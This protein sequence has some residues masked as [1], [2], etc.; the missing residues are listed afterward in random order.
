LN[1]EWLIAKRILSRPARHASVFEP[2]GGETQSRNSTR[3]IIRITLTGIIISM[4]VMI[5]AIAVVTGFQKEIRE[6]IS[7]FGAHIQITGFDMNNSYESSP[8]S[9]NQ[10]FYPSLD[11]MEGIRHIQVFATKAGIIKTG[12]EIQGVLLKGVGSDYDWDF[13]KD[14]IKG[15]KVLSLSDTAKSDEVLL[16][17]K[18]ADK[19]KLN[20]GD[21][22][23]MHF[24]QMPPRYRK[25]T[26]AGIYS[27]GLEEFDNLFVFCDIAHIRKLNDWSDTQ[28]GGFEVLVKDFSKLDE[29]GKKV[30]AS[31]GPELNARTIREVYPQVFDWLNLQDVNAAIIIVLMVIVAGINMISALLIIML[32]RTNMIGMLKSMG[33]PNGSLR[34]IFLYTAAILI[35]RGM[36]WGN[37]IGIGLCLVQKYGK[38]IGL[39]QESYYISYVP[40]HISI[41]DILLLNAGTFIAC[42]AMML[43]PTMILSGITPVKAIRFR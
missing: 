40:V 5:A 16:S 43:L 35:G 12:T 39:N 18:I 15:G 4:A 38:I 24:I 8:V 22:F 32:E 13:F 1:Y 3:P 28:V 27:T 30:Y 14:K 36:L 34:K 29:V 2:D 23:I 9:M 31:I 10:Q 6:K 25:F 42:T 21:T 20:V 41:P 26:V 19:L 7:G 17:Q 33:M 37:I 11:T